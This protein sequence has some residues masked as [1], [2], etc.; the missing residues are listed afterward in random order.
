M[1][2][3]NCVFDVD[4]P[5]WAIVYGEE[6]TRCSRTCRKALEME[7]EPSSM[8]IAVQVEMAK[9]LETV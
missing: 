4:G 1:L 3:S 5:N 6:E 9:A 7:K 2:K 8:A